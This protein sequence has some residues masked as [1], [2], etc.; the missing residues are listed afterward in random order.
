M[1]YSFFLM[2]V[3]FL[4]PQYTLISTYLLDLMVLLY[5]LFFVFKSC[6]IRDLFMFFYCF[7]PCVFGKL[8]GVRVA[9]VLMY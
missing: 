7:S 6:L 9:F 4:F 5:C 1:F 8:L 2:F 3:W